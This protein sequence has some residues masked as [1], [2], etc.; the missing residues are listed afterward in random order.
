M[1]KNDTSAGYVSSNVQM[2]VE[3]VSKMG[4]IMANRFNVIGHRAHKLSGS[5]YTKQS[6]GNVT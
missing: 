2:N 6:D 3:S 1:K 4:M 5:V